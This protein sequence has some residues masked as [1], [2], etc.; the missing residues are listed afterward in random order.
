MQM[1][2]LLP[3]KAS[4]AWGRK[5]D[6]HTHTPTW[7]SPPC[8]PTGTA[9]QTAPCSGRWVGT[10][11]HLRHQCSHCCCCCCC[12]CCCHCCCCCCRCCCG[13]CFAQLL[14]LVHTPPGHTPGALPG[15]LPS[16]SAP[17]RAA[18]AAH[19]VGGAALREGGGG[20]THEMM[21][22]RRDGRG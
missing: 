12:C 21:C 5:M 10:R 2:L 8:S 22:M 7:R 3:R 13:R 14:A 15:L 19:A 9:L 11:C 17:A 20:N 1:S 6:T 18:S 16:A 4:S